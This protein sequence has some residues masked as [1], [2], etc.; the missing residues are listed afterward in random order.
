MDQLPGCPMKRPIPIATLSI[1]VASIAATYIPLAGQWLVYDRT[2]IIDGEIWRLATGCLYHFSA[3][4]LWCNLIPLVFIGICVE[5]QSGSR[6]IGTCL[7]MA[8]AIGVSLF[9]AHPSMVRFGGASGL[10]CGLFAYFGFSGV[11]ANGSSGTVCRITLTVIL[12][13]IGCELYT[14]D[15]LWVDWEEQGFVVMPLSHVAG[16]LSA[17]LCILVQPI[18]G[19]IKAYSMNGLIHRARSAN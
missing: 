10:V 14:S 1:A 3:F 12:L 6:F 17:P 7:M 13:K 19:K 4:H 2:A 8:M 18:I 15:A 5:R 11:N 16:C 9:F